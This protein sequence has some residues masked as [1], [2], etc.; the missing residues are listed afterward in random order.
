MGAV[1]KT[2][3]KTLDVAEMKKLTR[4]CGMTKLDTIRNE[5]IRETAKVREIS[6]K[7]EERSLKLYRH[8]MHVMREGVCEGVKD[9]I[10]MPGKRRKR[11]PELRWMDSITDGTTKK[12]ERTI[13]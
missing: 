3:D 12:G 9:A 2:Q 4:I 5:R 13:R 11:I 7:V 1:K 6:K 10:D 8:A